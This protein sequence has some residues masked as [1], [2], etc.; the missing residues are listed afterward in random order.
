VAAIGDASQA[1]VQAMDELAATAVRLGSAT[2]ELDA[3][4]RCFDLEPVT[5]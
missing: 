4:V 1:S 5:G 3:L 2:H